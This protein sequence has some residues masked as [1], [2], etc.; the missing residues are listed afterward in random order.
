MS[1]RRIASAECV[2]IV[3]HVASALSAAHRRNLVHRDVKPENVLLDEDGN[4]YLSDF[5]I[6]QD[7]ASVT[8]RSLGSGDTDGYRSPEDLLG[9]PA[10]PRSDISRW[11]VMVA[12]SHCREPIALEQIAKSCARVKSI[13]LPVPRT[14]PSQPRHRGRSASATRERELPKARL[15]AAARRPCFLV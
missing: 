15:Q 13:V 7:M 3:D 14:Y 10:T 9:E 4:A 2:S 1:S 12:F 6:A 8:A 5:G 11:G